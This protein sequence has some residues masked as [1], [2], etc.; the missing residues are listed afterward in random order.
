MAGASVLGMLALSACSDSGGGRADGKLNVTASFYPM[1]FLAKEIG[2]DHV[3]VTD[4]TSPGTEPH[5]LE[6]TPGRPPTSASRTR[7]ST[8]RASSPP[9][10]RSSSS[11]AYGTSWTPPP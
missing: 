2:K 5:D 8:S 7:S 1:E 6:L 3:K 9:S 11:P 4:L 10:T